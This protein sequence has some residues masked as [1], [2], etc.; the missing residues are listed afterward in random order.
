MLHK[1]QTGLATLLLTTTIAS[2]AQADSIA[3]V[4]GVS[5]YDT[6]NRAAASAARDARV[7]LKQAGFALYGGD[8]LDRRAMLEVLSL[9]EQDANNATSAVVFVAGNF[10]SKGQA[11]WLIPPRTN[12]S[13]AIGMEQGA[14]SLNAILST[15]DP[16]DGRSAAFVSEGKSASGPRPGLQMHLGTVTADPGTAVL[17]GEAPALAKS[18]VS[19]LRPDAK[20]ANLVQSRDIALIGHA[21]PSLVLNPAPK[22][23]A[24]FTG[25]GGDRAAWSV[26]NAA[27]S[28]AGYMAYLEQFPQGDFANIA[29]SRLQVAAAP[30]IDPALEAEQNLK[31]DRNARRDVQRK[32]TLLGYSTRGV[33]GIFGNGS[34]DA[35]KRFQRSTGYDPTGF[36]SS[37]ML[38]ELDRR[39]AMRQAEVEEEE[40]RAKQQAEDEDIR[41][42][43][44][45]G[46]SGRPDDLRAYLNR[47]PNGLYSNEARREMDRL[48]ISSSS[49]ERDWDQAFRQDT[50]ASYETYL[51]AQ[52]RGKFR[53]DAE[54]RIRV[55]R[56]NAIERPTKPAADPAAAEKALKLSQLDRASLELRLGS[57]GFNPGFPEGKLDKRARSAIA[58]FQKKQG[59]SATGYFDRPTVEA[60]MKLSRK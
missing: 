6:R 29:R 5:D 8:N 24:S 46:S 31:L 22:P 1:I 16:L 53:R 60:I 38:R 58:A 50:I 21:G 20:V 55:L 23:S 35:I 51:K 10:A 34:R 40:R 15:L 4:L 19:A 47:Y 17:R 43:R 56:A 18:L 39:A 59:M 54:T 37:S 26:A 2:T 52:P 32:L 57:I 27:D 45:T 3:L 11:N 42:W 30:Q 28:E 25:I 14:V 49:D 13:T 33:D 12:A 44:S 48:G 41:F 36:L 9:F 7:A